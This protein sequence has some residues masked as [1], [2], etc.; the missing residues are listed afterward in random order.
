MYSTMSTS[1]AQRTVYTIVKDIHDIMF[2]DGVPIEHTKAWASNV[3][4]HIVGQKTQY[5]KPVV[6]KAKTK[7]KTKKYVTDPEEQNIITWKNHPAEKGWK[8]TKD[9]HFGDGRFPLC[10]PDGCVVA[11]LGQK[12]SRPLT[13]KDIRLLESLNIPFDIEAF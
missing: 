4:E 2:L 3:Y 5:K 10:N 8:Y 11:A 6:S 12:D 9:I 7:T 1:L 13:K